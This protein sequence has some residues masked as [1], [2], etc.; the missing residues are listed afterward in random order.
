VIAP[1]IKVNYGALLVALLKN[2]EFDAA[3]ALREWAAEWLFD[4]D[5]IDEALFEE[6]LGTDA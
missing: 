4:A 6:E 5:D 3:D 2:G 1:E